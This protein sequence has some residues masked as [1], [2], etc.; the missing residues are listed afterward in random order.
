MTKL[1]LVDLEILFLGIKGNGN[2]NENDIENSE[3]KRLGVGRILDSLASLKDRKMIELNKDGTF[4]ITDLARHTLWNEKIPLGVRIMKIL[5]IK[6]FTNEE[7]SKYLQKSEKEIYDEIENL[8]KSNLVLMSPQRIDSKII[9]VFEILPDGIEKLKKIEVEGYGNEKIIENNP[10]IDIMSGLSQ[11]IKEINDLEIMNE[12]K[13]KI[14][15][16]I[17]KIKEKMD[18]F[19]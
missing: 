6:S 14:I 17:N 1:G 13:E 5:E 8:R 12:E 11:L 7:I 18:Y 2:F 16:K 19:E 10:T 15:S 3:L 9:R 4:K